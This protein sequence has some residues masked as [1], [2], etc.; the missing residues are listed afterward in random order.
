MLLIQLVVPSLDQLEGV[1]H[2]LTMLAQALTLHPHHQTQK[3]LKPIQTTQW[4]RKLMAMHQANPQATSHNQSLLP[5][6]T[7]GLPR[8]EICHSLMSLKTKAKAKNKKAR[9]L[10]SIV[11]GAN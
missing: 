7:P 9:P 4:M 5:P 11:H 10:C 3:E 2:S 1:K 6:P 8:I